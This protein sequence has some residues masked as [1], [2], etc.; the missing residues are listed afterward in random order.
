MWLVVEWIEEKSVSV[1]REKDIAKDGREIKDLKGQT[2]NVPLSGKDGFAIH[3]AE[4]LAIYGKS[5]Y[6]YVSFYY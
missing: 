4:V 2:V 1:I 6:Y 3:E 5:L